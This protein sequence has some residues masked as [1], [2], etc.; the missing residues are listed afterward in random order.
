LLKAR[1]AGTLE[2]PTAAALVAISLSPGSAQAYVATANSV[3]CDVTTFT[4]SYLSNT[5]KFAM[6][7]AQDVMPCGGSSSLTNSSLEIARARTKQIA[8]F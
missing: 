2:Q 8:G 6:P 1:E 3:Q 4:G 5:S 7:P